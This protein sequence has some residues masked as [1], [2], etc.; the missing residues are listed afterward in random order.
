MENAGNCAEH[1]MT[2]QPISYGNPYQQPMMVVQ[3]MPQQ[4][5]PCGTFECK[6]KYPEQFY[7]STCKKNLTSRVET[8]W[9]IGAFVWCCCCAPTLVLAFLPLCVDGLRDVQHSCPLCQQN[10][11]KSPCLC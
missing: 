3:T 4:E 6:G 11:G 9:G 8:S 10:V 7:C 2:Q 1:L 5:K